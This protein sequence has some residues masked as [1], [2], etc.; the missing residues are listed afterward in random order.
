MN[1]ILLEPDEIGPDGRATLRD[2]RAE[3]IR[4]VLHGTPGMPLKTGIVN[5]PAGLSRILEVTPGSVTLQTSRGEP[6]PG[7][8]VDLLLAAPRPKTLRRLWPQLAALGARRIFLLAA[9]KVEK[10]YFGS[11]WLTPAAY[12]PLLIEGL[13]Q[14]GA[15]RLPEV[16]V[17][18]HL[19]SFLEDE[20]DALFAG[21]P[22]RLLAHPSAAD[23]A[24]GPLPPAARTGVPVLA[25]GPEGGWT[26]DETALFRRHGFA[27]FSL[28]PRIL[29]TDTACI[30][31]LAVLHD[32]MRNV[33]MSYE[34]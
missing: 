1:R 7:P 12:R 31:L 21:Q 25:I 2:A 20:S 34:L 16:A 29:R 27:M 4:S 6:A 14:A 15:T 23:A 3:H 32:R 28:G 17:R 13:S 30:A 5:G 11:H 9:A 33:V 22:F 24:A 19:K 18:R 8:W 26:D 10:C